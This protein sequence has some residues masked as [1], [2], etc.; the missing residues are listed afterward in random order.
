MSSDPTVLQ[1]MNDMSK[2]INFDEH[3]TVIEIEDTNNPNVKELSLK[4][5][6]WGGSNPWFVVDE[7][8]EIHTMM[9]VNAV[10]K[11]VE[12]F[13]MTQEENFNLKLEKS[14]WQNIPIDFQDVWSVAMQRVKELAKKETKDDKVINIDLSKLVTKIKKEHP[15][16][17]MDAKN[18]FQF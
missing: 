13:Q 10:Q 5:G 11:I 17:F 4:S 9:P 6:S 8:S 16:L 15:N 7:S 14:I 3:K 2:S 1:M 12:N 18:M